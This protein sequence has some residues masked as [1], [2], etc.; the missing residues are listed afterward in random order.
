MTDREYMLRAIELAKRGE[1]WC[2][3]NP[4]VGAVI[5]KDGRIIGE[6]YHERCGELHAE[7]NAFA[8]LTEDAAGATMYVTM[9][10]C[11]H[12]GK[13]P[14]CTL[15]V[16]EHRIARVFVGSR[17]PNPKVDGGGFRQLEEAGVEVIKDFC[18][19]ECDAINPVFFHYITTR[20]PYVRLKYAMTADGKIATRT[21][22]S[23]WI[24]GEAARRRVQEM[25]HADMAILAGIGTVLADDP[26]LTCRLPGGR[27][28][29]R[30]IC[31]S[32]L[33]LPLS[34]QI[35]RTAKE[36][37]TI[38]VCGAPPEADSAEAAFFRDRRSAL[39]AAG[40]EVLSLPGGDGRPDLKALTRLLGERKI[41][42]LLIEGGAGINEAA[43]R[44][45]IVNEVDVFVAP[46]IFGGRA[47]S[48]V[49]GAGV[50]SPEEAW[51]LR[52][53]S[54]EQIGGDLLLTYRT[55]GAEEKEASCSQES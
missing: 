42:S 1:G 53:V 25:R 14:P 52:L 28:P 22:A 5:V 9:E 48:P 37:E 10:P 38:A 17:D 13:Q 39:E 12:Y 49:E 46:K 18:R 23:K 55:A 32:S 2:H 15:A 36:F 47:L 24:T 35:V 45:G 30:L 34:S 7:R 6:G 44:A 51:P 43:L 41:D 29:V 26:L 40:V 27:S 50:A 33:R 21:G 3:P 19:E 16:I 54:I 4:K 31:D 8:H 20:T 11:C